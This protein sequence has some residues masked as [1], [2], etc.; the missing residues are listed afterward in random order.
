[1]NMFDSSLH[2]YMHKYY[3]RLPFISC[4]KVL[5]TNFDFNNDICVCEI[6]IPLKDNQ[7]N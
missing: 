6:S 1:M 3:L 5:G 4:Q 2:F 7:T